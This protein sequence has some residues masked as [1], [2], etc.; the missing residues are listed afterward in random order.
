MTLEGGADEPLRASVQAPAIEI[1]GCTTSQDNVARV[2]SSLRR[3]DGVTHV[4]VSS[5]EKLDQTVGVT[6]DSGGDQSDCRHGDA[7]Y[8]QFSM[9]LFFAVPAARAP[10][11]PREPAPHDPARSPRRRRRRRRR[12]VAV[13]GFWFFALAPK[14]EESADLASQIDAASQRLDTDRQSA[15]QARQAKAKYRSDYAA[16]AKLGKAVPQR[17]ALP[18]L[19]YQLRSAAGDAR[20][21]FRSL[22]LSASARYRVQAR[23]RRRRPRR[24]GLALAPRRVDGAPIDFGAPWR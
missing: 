22:K 18:S 4:S 5:A 16:V 11:P 17:D 12:R 19:L 20:I 8:P 6:G 7:R 10:R 1:V 21:D 24:A 3:V 15:A 14:R 9:T 23:R 13:A 2:I